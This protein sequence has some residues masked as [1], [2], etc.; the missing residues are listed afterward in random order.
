MLG[1]QLASK[2]LLWRR[3][4]KTR[5]LEGDMGPEQQCWSAGEWKTV[6]ELRHRS[7]P[8][9]GEVED[10]I[11]SSWA[12]LAQTETHEKLEVYPKVWHYFVQV[13][14]VVEFVNAGP[15]QQHSS[16]AARTTCWPGAVAAAGEVESHLEVE[17]ESE[18]DLGALIERED[19]IGYRCPVPPGQH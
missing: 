9:G 18:L 11:E 3:G 1:P 2:T 7:L 13:A 6:G 17:A 15:D 4:V 5:A 8:V 10:C 12:L 14:W 16:W 19:G